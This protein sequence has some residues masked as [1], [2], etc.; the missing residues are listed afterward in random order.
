MRAAS[1]PQWVPTPSTT[2]PALHT[3]L[4]CMPDPLVKLASPLPPTPHRITGWRHPNEHPLVLPSAPLLARCSPF[5][6]RQHRYICKSL[7]ITTTRAA[8]RPSAAR[9]LWQ[10]CW[11]RWHGQQQRGVDMHAFTIALLPPPAS[12]QQRRHRAT[13]GRCA[14]QQ[15]HPSC[16]ASGTSTLGAGVRPNLAGGASGVTLGGGHLG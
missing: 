10:C 7:H 5:V 1:P 9:F 6:L 16:H 8:P 2:P 11:Q 15:K 3:V 13:R 14:M 4:P 12:C